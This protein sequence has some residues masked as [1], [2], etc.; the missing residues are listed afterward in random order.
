[1]ST[2]GDEL[3][4]AKQMAKVKDALKKGDNQ[5]AMD[6]LSKTADKMKEMEGN[7][8]DLDDLREQLKRL[9]DAKDSC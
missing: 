4:M 2:F 1:M 5:M 3:N 9:Q 6:E 7:D 8:Q